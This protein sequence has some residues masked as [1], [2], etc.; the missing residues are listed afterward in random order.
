MIPETMIPG[1]RDRRQIMICKKET[2]S[3]SFMVP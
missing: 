1:R 3:Y 2:V